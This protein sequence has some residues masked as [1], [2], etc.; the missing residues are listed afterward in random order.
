MRIAILDDDELQL[1]LIRHLLEKSGFHCHAFASGRALMHELRRESFDLLVLDWHVPDV[2]GPEV[3]K[4]VR[5]GLD[6]RPDQ[7]AAQRIPVLFVT[8]RTSEDDIVAGLAA[9]A[10]DYMIKPLRP[11]ELVARVQA[12][13]RRAHPGKV[14]DQL[15]FEPYRFEPQQSEV[16]FT[17]AGTSRTVALTQKEF[18]L[19]LLLFRN[20]GRPLSRS[21]IRETVW[22]SDVEIPS[23]TMDTHVSRIRTKLELGPEAGY[24]VMPVYSYGYRLDRIGAEKEK[25][26]PE[27]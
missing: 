14:R 18:D 15:E 5:E 22:G 2:S 1:G 4:W 13:L 12:L 6:Q 10:D 25:A 27:V 3:L 9:G 21:H 8:G 7:Q 19:A 23:R 16:S 11:S 24:R 20:A 17:I 26:I